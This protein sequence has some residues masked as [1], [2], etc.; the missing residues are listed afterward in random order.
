MRGVTI[1]KR[2]STAAIP[3]SYDTRDDDPLA[4]YWTSTWPAEH[5]AMPLVLPFSIAITSAIGG[6]PA[7]AIC[8]KHNLTS[9]RL[10]DY[11]PLHREWTILSVLLLPAFREYCCKDPAV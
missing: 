2:G 7:I 11:R 1:V 9:P 8:E 4:T 3:Y 6:I 5:F 10:F